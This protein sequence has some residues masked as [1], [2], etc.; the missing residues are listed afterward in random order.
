MRE[1][2]SGG[3]QMSQYGSSQCIFDLRPATDLLACPCPGRRLLTL[4][5]RPVRVFALTPP[6]WER[7]CR[8]DADKDVTQSQRFATGKSS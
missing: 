3:R 8:V 4:D 5:L 6:S 1:T 7:L 2:T